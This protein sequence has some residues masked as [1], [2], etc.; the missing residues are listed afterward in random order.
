M[1]NIEKFLENL[2]K[3]ELKQLQ[4]MLNERGYKTEVVVDKKLY[5]FCIDGVSYT[6]K[7]AT[8]GISGKLVTSYSSKKVA[9]KIYKLYKK[10][11]EGC[12]TVKDLCDKF[13]L[14]LPGKYI[15]KTFY[16]TLSTN[17]VL[18]EDTVCAL[19]FCSFEECEYEGEKTIKL[20]TNQDAIEIFK[21]LPIN[22]IY[23]E[24]MDF[25]I[26]DDFKSFTI[27]EIIKYEDFLNELRQLGFN[28]YLST[29]NSCQEDYTFEDCIS[30]TYNQD[31]GFLKLVDKDLPTYKK[32][33]MKLSK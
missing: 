23:I 14:K 8:T 29:K 10:S 9:R 22:M 12:N 21:K 27:N 26:G 3:E 33:M 28:V 5:P 16:V 11:I 7:M 31:C 15:P 2:T 32:Y 19:E 20:E 17:P 30:E 13:R 4:L 6:N 25:W 18:D 1:N 24:D